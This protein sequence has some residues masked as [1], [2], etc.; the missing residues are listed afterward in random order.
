MIVEVL[1]MT[2]AIAL[3]GVG[4]VLFGITQLARQGT[5][6][7]LAVPVWARWGVSIVF[8]LLVTGGL[9]QLT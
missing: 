1:Q 2:L 9:V 7:T 5:V 6:V 4:V 3:F 8:L